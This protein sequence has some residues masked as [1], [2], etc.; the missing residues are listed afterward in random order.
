VLRL[1]VL[2]VIAVM[3]VVGDIRFFVRR[4]TWAKR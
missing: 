1:G 2:T 4:F 3:K